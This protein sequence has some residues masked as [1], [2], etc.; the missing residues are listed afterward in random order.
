MSGTFSSRQPSASRQHSHSV[1]LSSSSHRVNR[2]KSVNQGASTTA[3]AAIAA[4]LRDQSGMPIQNHRRSLGSRKNTESHSMSSR[5][6]MHSYFHNGGS[7]AAGQDHD[8]L[9]DN[10]NDEE[11]SSKHTKNRNRRASDGAALIQTESKKSAADLRCNTCGKGYKHSSCLT[12][13]LYVFES[14]DR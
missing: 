9:E 7:V 1:S 4:A 3:Q 2:R 12:K 14:K 8:A 10:S 6:N 5:P 11:T 13:H